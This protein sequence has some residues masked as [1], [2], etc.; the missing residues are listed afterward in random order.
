MYVCMSK[1]SVIVATYIEVKSTL[2]SIA[3]MAKLYQFTFH[4]L[5]KNSIT[6]HNY[7]KVASY[8]AIA[9]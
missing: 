8:L 2:K 3:S 7:I 6:N 1:F 5:M 4:F 9:M